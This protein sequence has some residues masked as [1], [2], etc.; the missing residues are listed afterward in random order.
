MPMLRRFALLTAA[1]VLALASTSYA[2]TLATPNVS[3]NN[4]GVGLECEVSNLNTKAAVVTVTLFDTSGNAI[5]SNFDNC[6]ANPLPAGHTCAVGLPPDTSGR[7]VVV[8]KAAKIRAD[9]E[10]F[11][12]GGVPILEVP[13]TK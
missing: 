12:S 7:C 11:T 10:V 4:G 1:A 5:S 2:T 8:T 9:V 13:A 6:N 3:A